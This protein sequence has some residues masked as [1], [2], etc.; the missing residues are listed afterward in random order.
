MIQIKTINKG[1]KMNQVEN[2]GTLSNI[3]GFENDAITVLSIYTYN[4]PRISNVRCMS[5]NH[6]KFIL[7]NRYGAITYQCSHCGTVKEEETKVVNNSLSV[8]RRSIGENPW[9]L[10]AAS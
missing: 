7:N 4:R 8:P 1:D 5:C 9:P 6:D 2:G 10:N 3:K